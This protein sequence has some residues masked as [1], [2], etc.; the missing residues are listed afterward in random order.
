MIASRRDS[1]T[2]PTSATVV[3][4][5][6]IDFPRRYNAAADLVDGHLDAGRGARVAYV[7]DAP[8]ATCTYAELAA[9][10]SRAGNALRALGVAMEQRVAIAMLDSVD[11]VAAFLGAIKIGA[12]PVPLNTLL[13]PSDY[14]GSSTTAA[15]AS[16]SCRTRSRRSSKRPSRRRRSPPWCSSRVR[17]LP[18]RGAKRASAR[19]PTSPS[20]TTCA[21][22]RARR[23]IPAP[24]TCDDVA[25]WLY[26]SGSTGRPKG[27]MHLHTHLR[28]HERALR[29]A[30]ARPPRGRRRSSPQRSSFSRTASATR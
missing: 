12:V 11:F 29:R 14:A 7:E 1:A 22:R 24:T 27:A 19:A 28:L 6:S 18:A 21:R 9:R 16:S 17:L 25:F 13:T 23:S 10:V 8:H 3:A 15:R 4:V 20:S 26:S 2:S 5:P 30:G